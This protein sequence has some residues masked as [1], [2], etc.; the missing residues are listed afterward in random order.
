M[1][2]LKERLEIEIPDCGN[3]YVRWIKLCGT[4]VSIQIFFKIVPRKYLTIEAIEDDG[5]S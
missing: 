4:R 3:A 5:S 1:N 2:Y